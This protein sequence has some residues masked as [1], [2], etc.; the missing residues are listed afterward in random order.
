MIASKLTTCLPKFMERGAFYATAWKLGRYYRTY[1]AY[2]QDEVIAGLNDAR[3]FLR[4]PGNTK[5]GNAS[6]HRHAFV[7]QDGHY[8]SARWPGDAY[9]FAE[10][11]DELLTSAERRAPP[12][13]IPS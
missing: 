5:R 6:D 13:T 8:L 3:Q 10:R 12:E 11:F 7:V 1:P 9:L 2:V 4:G